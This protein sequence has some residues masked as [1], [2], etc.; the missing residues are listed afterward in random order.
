[1]EEGV[2]CKFQPPTPLIVVACVS[3]ALAISYIS[4]NIAVYVN[5]YLLPGLFN[6]Q[7]LLQLL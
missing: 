1:M 5:L 6:P 3:Q 2:G 7:V 4:E